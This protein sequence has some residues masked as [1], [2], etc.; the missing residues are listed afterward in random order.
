MSRKFEE[1]LGEVLVAVGEALG[2]EGDKLELKGSEGEEHHSHPFPEEPSFLGSRPWRTTT[3]VS[4]SEEDPASKNPKSSSLRLPLE[5]TLVPLAAASRL[6]PSDLSFSRFAPEDLLPLHDT[7]QRL[8]G[9]CT[10]IQG[11]W[12]LIEHGATGLAGAQE[13]ASLP[14]TP[15]TPAISRVASQPPSPTPMSIGSRAQAPIG[16]NPGLDVDGSKRISRFHLAGSNSFQASNS[17]RSPYRDMESGME[18][19]D[20]RRHLELE[21]GL[22]SEMTSPRWIRRAYSRDSISYVD[23]PLNV[24]RE[25]EH[26]GGRGRKWGE[27]L[28]LEEGQPRSTSVERSPLRS[29]FDVMFVPRFADNGGGGGHSTDLAAEGM[30]METISMGDQTG[31]K[32]STALHAPGPGY[33]HVQN[34]T[35][36]EPSIFEKW[37]DRH[38]HMD[39]VSYHLFQ[40]VLP[41]CSML[42]IFFFF[43]CIDTCKIR[44]TASSSREPSLLLLLQFLF[45]DHNH[46]EI[47]LYF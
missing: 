10:G 6:V 12:G 43:V 44:C 40:T 31:V 34:Q 24:S 39:S 30:E 14:K 45:V 46:G 20:E 7:C 28:K 42:S 23:A 21:L 18:R 9:Q 29:R 32:S 35:H 36:R 27:H 41:C 26:R 2:D 13:G 17:S 5:P 11:F 4:A 33:G 38:L 25:G 8:V 47:E 1:C 16:G 3:P 19:S 37:T 15:K 22:D